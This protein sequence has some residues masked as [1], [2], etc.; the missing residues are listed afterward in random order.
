M[1]PHLLKSLFSS[2]ELGEYRTLAC[3]TLSICI[4][5]MS[6]CCIQSQK[7]AAELKE[8]STIGS[9]KDADAIF[10]FVCNYWTD[11]GAALGN[12]VKELLNKLIL[13]LEKIWSPEE[14]QDHLIRWAGQVLKYPRSMRV[15]YFT[16]EILARQLGGL[17]ILKLEPHI[18][19]DSLALIYSNAL[20]NPIGK[21]L[22]A[23]LTTSRKQ[24]MATA[25]KSTEKKLAIAEIEHVEKQ[26]LLLWAEDVIEALKKEDLRP[27]VFTYLLPNLFKVSA[28][29]FRLFIRQ[30]QGG[31]FSMSSEIDITVLIGCLK[32]GQDLSILE[33]TDKSSAQSAP[34]ISTEFLQTLL[35]Q[36]SQD[37]RLGGLSLAV[38]SP[39]A[40]KPISLDILNVLAESLDDLT[41]ESDPEF[42]NRVYGYLRQMITRI[43]DSSYSMTRERSKL[44]RQVKERDEQRIM[45]LSAAIDLNRTF[46]ENYLLYLQQLLRPGSSY[47]RIHMGL[48]LLLTVVRSGLDNRVDSKW[49]D[50]NHLDFPYHIS[51][52]SATTI[53]LLLDNLVNNYEDIREASGSLLKI[54]PLSALFDGIEEPEVITEIVDGYA[55]KGISMVSG[56]RGREGDGG[57]RIIEFCYFLYAKL[58]IQRATNLHLQF[59]SHV[60]QK[61]EDAIKQAEENLSVAVK[62]Y[63]LHGYFT[64][65]RLAFEKADFADPKMYKN[66]SGWSQLIKRIVGTTHSVWN[67]VEKILSH[68]SPE[69]NMPEELEEQ[70]LVNLE[71]VYG[72]ATQVILSYAWRAIGESSELLTTLLTVVPIDSNIFAVQSISKLGNL[73]LTELST[74]RHR[75]AFSSVFPAFVACCVR[76]NKSNSAAVLDLPRRWLDENIQLIQVKSQNITRRSGGLPYLVAGVLTAEADDS[77]RPLLCETFERLVE[78]AQRP[79]ASLDESEKTDLPQVHAL[80]CIRSIFIETRLSTASA[81]FIDQALAVA[82]DAFASKVWSIRNC[83]VMLFAALQTRLFGSRKFTDSRMAVGNMSARL[84][85]SRFKSIKGVLLRHLQEHVDHLEGRAAQTHIETVY[86]VLSLLSRLEATDSYDG[87]VAFSPYITQCLSSRIW[88]V[89]A[90][91]NF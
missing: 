10:D 43:R 22:T 11:S 27:H 57:A 83:G 73:L 58:D 1:Y 29:G 24:M 69:G 46:L 72:P 49:H 25:V 7:Y 14:R 48:K 85:F 26:W 89:R 75:G 3:D 5:R 77:E 16:I 23:I 70:Y 63:P 9:V 81:A 36:S 39:R 79:P 17:A 80:N 30:L 20:A 38:S 15:V 35:H 54:A 52:Y 33:S 56:L 41:L 28:L 88:K 32:I 47:Q 40:S 18:I 65:L 74:I 21:M 19:K 76:C 53:R 59:L 2:P 62:D 86:P 8:S 90:H 82:I 71:E 45:E 78:I 67:I 51:I 4:Q 55:E 84:F 42:R 91:N 64:C 34:I 44:L 66:E 61:L 68:D 31:Q 6:Q 37:L 50:K 87:L 12:A 60:V 13:L